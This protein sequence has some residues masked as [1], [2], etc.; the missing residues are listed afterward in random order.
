MEWPEHIAEKKR[1]EG[2]V[3][4]WCVCLDGKL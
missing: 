4:R 2:S 1:N 3:F